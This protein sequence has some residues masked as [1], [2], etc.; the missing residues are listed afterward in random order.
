MSEAAVRVENLSV[1]VAGSPALIV[2]EIGFAIGAGEVL[3][4]VG[5]SGSG[6]TTVGLALLGHARRGSEIRG[7]RA[8]IAGTELLGLSP[9]ARRDRRGRLVAYIPQDPS[10]ALNPA[11]LIG[12]QLEEMLAVHAPALDAAARARRIAEMLGEVRLPQDPAFLRRYPHQ[13]SGGQQQRVAI[14]MAFACRPPAIVLDEPTTGLDVTTQAHVLETIRNLCGRYGVA[15]LY[16]SHDLA[17][18]ASLAD[19]GL[20]MY[21]GRG[22]EAAPTAALFSRPRH[23]YTRRLLA[24]VPDVDG[25]HRLVGI[26]GYAPSPRRRP[27]G[28]ASRRAARRSRMVQRSRRLPPP[29][30]GRVTRCAAGMLRRSAGGARRCRHRS[31]LP[32]APSR[33]GAGVVRGVT[34]RHGWCRCAYLASTSRCSRGSAR[35]WSASPAAARPRWRA[36][37]PGCIRA[38][39]A[40]SRSTDAG[41]CRTAR[42]TAPPP[43]G[44]RCSTSSRAPMP[45][46]N[47]RRTIGQIV[48]RPLSSIFTALTPARRR[49]R[50][51]ALLE[52]VAL[53]PAFLDRFPDQ[54]SGGERQRAAI[55]RALA[56]EPTVLVCD[57]ITSAL[58]VSVQ[59]A[60]VELLGELQ[61]SMQLGM[62]FV[63]H[64]LALIRTIADRVVVMSRGRIVESGATAAVFAQ[65]A[66]DYTRE[67]LASTPRLE[68]SVP[69]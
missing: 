46:L 50:A 16:V 15:A 21:S 2:D 39:T 32:A 25:R 53:G 40:R 62:L 38:S 63:T 67:L 49:D 37:S 4:L 33:P 43:T 45:R 57:E 27:P 20:V 30:S 54:L 68:A 41:A 59:A 7:G 14:A 36:A 55:A 10:T 17:V 44:A 65:P 24:A 31:R 69:A 26:P 1:G 42:A 13:L 48:S 58:D 18:V 61:R 28:C 9:E 34:A 8:T 3:G 23:P 22:V 56:A 5:E 47:P 12:L 35:R 51:A 52:Q 66:A 11:L 29:R 19:R 60:I 64:N 6:K